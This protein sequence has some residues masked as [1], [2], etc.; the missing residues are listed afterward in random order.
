MIIGLD[1]CFVGRL[2]AALFISSYVRGAVYEPHFDDEVVR[3]G[4][5]V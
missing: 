2:I 3:H 4:V 1:K 5:K